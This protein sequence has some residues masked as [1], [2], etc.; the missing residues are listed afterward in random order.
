VKTNFFPELEYLQTDWRFEYKYRLSFQQYLQVRSAI[1]PAMQIDQYSLAAPQKRYLVRSLYLDTDT[2]TNYVEKVHGDCDRVKLRI[3]S[4]SAEPTRNLPLR[5]EFKA[6][7]GITVE[8]HSTW[9]T[10][11]DYQKFI[12]YRHWS[13]STDPVLIEF[14]RY[15][16]M[17]YLRPKIIVEYNREGYRAR[18]GENVRVTFDHDIRSAHAALLF[19]GNPFFHK[20]HPGQIVLEIKCNEEQAP[21]LRYMVEQFGLRPC[22]N[23]KYIQGIN[24]SRWD[25]VTPAW[26]C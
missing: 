14:E 4:Y 18:S 25:V 16:H 2:L 13:D 21:W 15:V 19:P 17:K 8:K 11:A 22:T 9:I 23:S 1:R 12:S 5:A 7:R 10:M 20:H 3:R 24:A 6:R 26:S